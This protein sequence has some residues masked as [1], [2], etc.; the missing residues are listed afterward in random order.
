MAN[1]EDAYSAMSADAAASREG[2]KYQESAEKDPL[3]TKEGESNVPPVVP[4][5]RPE[6]TDGPDADETFEE[7]AAETEQGKTE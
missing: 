1:P 4:Q 3:D 6:R 7:H 5:E 2:K